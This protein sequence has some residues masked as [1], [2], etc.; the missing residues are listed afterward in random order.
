M[1]T[2]TL[3]LPLEPDLARVG[4][5][6]D[7]VEKPG[8]GALRRRQFSGEL[9]DYEF[10]GIV[11]SS[12]AL[13]EALDLVRA[14]APTDSTV[15]IEG[16]TGT[17]KELIARAVHQ[18]S[19]RAQGTFVSINCGAL[20]PSLIASEL[21][22]HER[23]AFTGALQQRQGRFEQASGGTIFLD[24]VGELPAEMQVALL[25]VLQEREFERVGGTR[26]IRVDVRVIAATNR[27][28]EAAVANGTFRSDLFYRLNVFPI[29]VPPLRERKE[30]IP[31]LIDY[32]VQQF[33]K[34]IGRQFSRIDRRTLDLCQTYAWP[35]NVRELQ[36]VVERSVI[37]RRGDMFWIDQS[38]LSSQS[39]S[40]AG[41]SGARK[42]PVPRQTEASGFCGERSVI[43]EV[44]RETRGRVYGPRGAALKL[45]VPPSTLES[46]IRALNISKK[47]F[48]FS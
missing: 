37:C 33:A 13:A 43:E 47:Q 25:R 22:G 21:F 28:L 17:G 3:V 5:A 46:R 38:A 44:L 42:Q 10:A 24:E 29:E 48:K 6:D 27:D 11:G 26:S 19:N 32:F 4:S 31:L 30:D 9:S 16:E 12:A 15:L 14:V 7:E 40:E 23:G 45:R 20:A 41:S 18:C 8:N 1:G 36:N 35:G 2:E 34:K 39:L